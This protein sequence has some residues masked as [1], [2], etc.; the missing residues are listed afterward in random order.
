MSSKCLHSSPSRLQRP[1]PHPSRDIGPG[2]SPRGP[3]R[4]ARKPFTDEDLK[5][6]AR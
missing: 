6:I 3:G 1:L 5:P 4:P 2:Q